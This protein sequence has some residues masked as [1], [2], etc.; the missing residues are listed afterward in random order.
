[1]S[2]P[3][4]DLHGAPLLRFW[5]EHGLLDA[6]T[7]APDLGAKLAQWVDVRQAIQLHQQLAEP[8][9]PVRP[10]SKPAAES[11]LLVQ[12]A[13]GQLRDAIVFDRFGPGLWRNPM[14]TDVSWQPLVWSELWE[15]YRRYLADHQKQIALVLSRL[16]RQMRRA[17]S[18]AG[19]PCHAL[20]QI[21]AVFDQT[22]T[23]RETHL[24]AR[25]PFQYEHRLAARVKGL[26]GPGQDSPP[27]LTATSPLN[28]LPS[29]PEWLLSFEHDIRQSLLAE[30]DLRAQPVLG[31]LDALKA[32]C[33]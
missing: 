29:K 25:L 14:P 20:A 16:R 4:V 28:R 31:L 18:D 5:F 17:L 12:E 13:L 7:S 30:L 11:E 24:L 8:E 26:D 21:D 22:L 15:P 33:P 32:H 6:P 3:V 23:A 10:V 19:G 2:S 1:M 27:S 9:Q